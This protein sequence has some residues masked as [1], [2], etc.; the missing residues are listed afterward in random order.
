VEGL[1]LVVS[2]ASTWLLDLLVALLIGFALVRPPAGGTSQ[3]RLWPWLVLLGADYLVYLLARVS[4]MSGQSLLDALPAV[5]MVVGQ[6]HFGLMWSV[7]AAGWLAM[8]VLACSG[9][10]IAR[11]LWPLALLAFVY[12]HAATGHVADAG[13]VSV[14]ALVHTGHLLATGAWAGSVLVFLLR[15][16][17]NSAA[18]SQGEARQLSDL[19]AWA[20]VLVLASGVLNT[21]RMLHGAQAPWGEPYGLL[22]IAKVGLV[23]VAL[24][25]GTVNRL[26]VLPRLLM[27]KEGARSHFLGL[28]YPE[29]AAFVLLFGL[30]ALLSATSPPG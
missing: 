2:A 6:T 3:P 18:F 1:T 21:W 14:A 7:G 20:M 28:L 13:F 12:S 24:T 9:V 26:G 25:L 11:R 8:L 16:R 19:A 22:L 15:H 27:N 29:A 5:G 23:A 17:G 4:S 10:A 30:A